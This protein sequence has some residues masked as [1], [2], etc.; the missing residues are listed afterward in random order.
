[1]SSFTSL[2]DALAVTRHIDDLVK[3]YNVS[4]SELTNLND[5]LM[6]TRNCILSLQHALAESIHALADV[7]KTSILSSLAGIRTVVDE[8]SQDVDDCVK[9]GPNVKQQSAT[10]PTPSFAVPGTYE[11]RLTF[12]ITSLTHAANIVVCGATI[13]A[14][15]GAEQHDST[16]S[17]G[18]MCNLK[19][20]GSSTSRR[21]SLGKTVKLKGYYE[22]ARTASPWLGGKSYAHP[23][24][25]ELIVT[26]D[27]L[28]GTFADDLGRGTIEGKMDSGSEH[29][30]ITFIKSYNSPFYLWATKW[31]YRGSFRSP[32]IAGEWY[33][34]NVPATHASHRGTFVAWLAQDDLIAGHG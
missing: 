3:R 26:P 24:D 8:I 30:Q 29:G 33:H 11:A 7:H 27:S 12:W 9:V 14:G 17:D 4:S 18:M 1:M 15:S 6:A 13:N 22:Y 20:L 16:S 32:G 10:P 25:Y 23:V 28:R 5:I 34:A 19:W 31:E 2:D 21:V